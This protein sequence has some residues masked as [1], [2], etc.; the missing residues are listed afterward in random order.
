MQKQWLFVKEYSEPKVAFHKRNQGS[1]SLKIF[2]LPL[3]FYPCSSLAE[4]NW[5]LEGWEPLESIYFR[6]WECNSVV[7]HLPSIRKAL[8]F[9]PSTAKEKEKEKAYRLAFQ[10][11]DMVKCRYGEAN[12]E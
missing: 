8:G 2:S 1:N 7:A 9:I 12:K 4:S 5:K 6:G 3:I 10:A 11:E